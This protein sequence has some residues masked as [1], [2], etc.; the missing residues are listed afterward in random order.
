MALLQDKIV[1]VNGGSQGVGA[2]IV[3]AAVR[4]GT[5]V[6]FTGRRVEVGEKLAA[7]TGALFVQAGLADPAQ[8]GASA[9][10]TVDA[11][12]RVDCLV[13]AAGLTS[14]GSLLDTTPELFD[15]HMAIN[16]RAPFFA[17]QAAVA[18]MKTRQAPGTIVNVGSNCAHGGP[19]YLA[20]T[21]R[22]RPGWPD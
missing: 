6:V 8:A 19:P 3:R 20:P 12:G 21:P 5:T 11:R 7:D 2:G 15:Q 1:L 4:E 22:P 13:N 16:L 9:A 10:R 18:D 14:R 17:M